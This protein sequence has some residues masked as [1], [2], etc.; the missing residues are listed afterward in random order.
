MYMDSI[1]QDFITFMQEVGKAQGMDSLAATIF[2]RL[3]IEPGEIAMSDLAEETGYS[4]ASISNKLKLL[5]RTGFITRRTRPG[6]RKV[7]LSADKDTLKVFVWQLKQL[8]AVQA[9]P[10]L[11]EIPRIVARYESEPLA[12]VQREKLRIMERYCEDM[13]LID[14]MIADLIARLEG[15]IS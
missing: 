7:Y 12:E 6:T 11:E 9:R 13:R 1:D 10:V 8:Q 3:F 14:G 5:E 4:L 15:E 2:A